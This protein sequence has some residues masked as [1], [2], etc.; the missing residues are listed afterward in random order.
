[1]GLVERARTKGYWDE[2]GLEG[3]GMGGDPRLGKWWR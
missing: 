2:T 3:M 1:M